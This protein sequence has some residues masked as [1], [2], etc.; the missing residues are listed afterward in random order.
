MTTVVV[1]HRSK[2]N[3]LLNVILIA[4]GLSAL[5]ATAFAF[6]TQG[7]R[8]ACLC[9]A[10]TNGNVDGGSAASSEVVSPLSDIA[11]VAVTGKEAAVGI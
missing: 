8:R 2:M 7:A 1:I 3:C 10:S 6:Q 4:A 5:S 11:R 9:L